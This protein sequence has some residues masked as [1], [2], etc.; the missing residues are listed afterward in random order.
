LYL[1]FLDT[2]HKVVKPEPEYEGNTILQN[3]RTYT[4]NNNASYRKGLNLAGPYQFEVS[5]VLF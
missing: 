3:L 4:P 5:N 1:Y 2:P